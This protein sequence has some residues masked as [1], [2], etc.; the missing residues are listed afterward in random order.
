MLASSIKSNDDLRFPLLAS[1]KL[2]GIRCIVKNGLALSR[3]LKPIPNKHVQGIL[4]RLPSDLVLD[5]ELIVGDPYHPNVMQKTTS[6]VMSENGEPSF[7]Y[8]IFDCIP[9]LPDHEYTPF[10]ERYDWLNIYVGGL[11]EDMVKHVVLLRQSVVT[12]IEELDRYEA[13][14]LN[15]GYEGV[16]V[17]DITGFYKFGRSTVK[18]GYLLKIKRFI[19][20]EALLMGVNELMH[21]E[22]ELTKDNFGLAKRSSHKVNQVPGGTM[23]SLRVKDLETQLEFEIGTG[24]TSELRQQIWNNRHDLMKYA[25]IIKYKHFNSGVKT[26]P[27]FPVFIGFRDPSDLGI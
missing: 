26:L 6:G 8:F 17:R 16:M 11:S 18:E 14:C 23:G 27:R 24:F 5:G 25:T 12:S 20:G 19:D 15:I 9:E 1:P 3:S 22:N 2:D 21:N 10:K 7:T 13:K 4:S